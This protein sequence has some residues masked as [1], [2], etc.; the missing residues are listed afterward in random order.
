VNNPLSSYY[1]LDRLVT[2]EELIYNL[3]DYND[4]VLN[5]VQ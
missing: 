2:G 1:S 3:K 4:Q 5:S